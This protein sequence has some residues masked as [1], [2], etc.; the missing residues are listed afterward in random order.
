MGSFFYRILGAAALDAGMYEGLEADRDATG[1]ALFVVLLSSLAAGIGASG[2]HGPSIMTVVLYG[3][4]ALVTWAAWAVLMFQ[5][6]ARLMPEAGTRSDLGE[7]LRTIGFAASPGLIQVFAAFPRVTIPVFV[8][9]WVWMFAATLTAVKHALDYR[10]TGRA[11]AVC[12]IAAALSSVV[13]VLLG[14]LFGPTLS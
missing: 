6:G 8:I 9:A 4:V 11:V 5:I 12:A 3:A 2:W 14:L 1:Q 10:S 7:L 13:A